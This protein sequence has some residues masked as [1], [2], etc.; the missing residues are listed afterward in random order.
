M[1]IFIQQDQRIFIYL[2]IF[3]LGHKNWVLCIAWSP[4]SEKLISACK[5]GVILAW[6]PNTGKQIGPAMIG[7]KQ[8]VTSL[9]W[10][11][12]HSSKVIV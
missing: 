6:D 8:W 5:N 11:P 3:V 12:F 10:E 1:K 7:H 2:F 4:D 9:A